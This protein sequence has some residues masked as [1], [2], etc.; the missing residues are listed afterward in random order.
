[1][2]SILF[3]LFVTA[4]GLAA[5]DLPPQVSVPERRGAIVV[6]GNIDE[7][8]W[9]NAAVITL[10]KSADNEDQSA[11]FQNKA[12]AVKLLWDAQYLYLGITVDDGEIKPMGKHHDDPV[13]RGD[14]FE[15]FIDP[16]ADRR[17]HFEIQ[18]NADN[19]TA[20]VNYLYT[21]G[22]TETDAA[23]FL[24]DWSNQWDDKSYNLK[25]FKHAAARRYDAGGKLLGWSAELAISYQELNRRRNRVKLQPGQVLRINFV[26]LELPETGDL[27]EMQCYIAVVRGRQ[28]R[29]LGRMGEFIL[30]SA[31]ASDSKK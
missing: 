17:Q 31:P 6:D 22:P 16:A 30:T 28:H 1:M 2:K 15:I 23:G 13:F 3:V 26:R 24:P 18:I 29:S 25:D 27:P 14:A 21:G 12:A 5:A 11:L 10:Q 8:A 4:A 9:G 20:D 19:A 7:A